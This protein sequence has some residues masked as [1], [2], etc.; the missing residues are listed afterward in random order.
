MNGEVRV[1]DSVPEAFATLVGELL[2]RPR[3]GGFS[4]FL[5]GGPTAGACYRQLARHAGQAVDWTAVDAYWGDERCVPIDDVDSN[6]RLGRQ[7]LLDHVGPLRSEHPMYR[8]GP[9]TNAAADYQHLLLGLASFDLIHLGMGPDGHCASIFPNSDALAVE[10]P[11]VLVVADRDPFAN[12]PHPRITL[13][14]PAIARARLVVFTVAGAPKHEAFARIVSGDDLPA[15]RVA[16][17]E[18]IWLIDTGVA[19]DLFVPAG[20]PC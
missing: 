7:T 9:P 19:G 20:S 10:D 17:D 8:S 1:V 12:N 15:A 11:D 4:L 5:S 18:V 16:A 3:A 13:T 2:A 6:H 14:L